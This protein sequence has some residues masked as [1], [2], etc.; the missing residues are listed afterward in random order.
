[1][2]E[3]LRVKVAIVISAICLV[4]S[5]FVLGLPLITLA[6]VVSGIC[7]AIAETKTWRVA[8]L[9]VAGVSVV[10]AIILV[11]GIIKSIGGVL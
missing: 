11:A 8:G 6:L 3:A 10:S 2:E 4:L 9:V 5:W 1:M 7:A